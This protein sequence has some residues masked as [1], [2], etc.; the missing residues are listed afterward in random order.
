MKNMWHEM[1]RVR[2]RSYRWCYVWMVMN[3]GISIISIHQFILCCHLTCATPMVVGLFMPFFFV[4]RICHR[5]N[6]SRQISSRISLEMFKT[7]NFFIHIHYVDVRYRY[8][9]C[10]FLKMKFEINY[11]SQAALYS[12]YWITVH[13]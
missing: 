7:I 1:E 4:I 8:M 6:H 12:Y 13:V 10:L 2:E 3:N 5:P 9:F 11:L